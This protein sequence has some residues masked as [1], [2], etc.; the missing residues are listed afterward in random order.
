MWP[1]GP[2]RSAKLRPIKN[3][4]QAPLRTET[5]V[6]SHKMHL[7]SQDTFQGRDL[8][9]RVKQVSQQNTS[10]AWIEW[11]AQVQ[12]YVNTHAVPNEEYS[13]LLDR[14]KALL[15]KCG[16]ENCRVEQILQ[17][18]AT[19]RSKMDTLWQDNTK[20]RLENEKMKEIGEEANML[21][22]KICDVDRIL[23]EHARLNSEIKKLKAALAL[24]DN[25][26]VKRGDYDK[27][28]QENT[29]LIECLKSRDAI[30]KELQES[31]K[32]SRTQNQ[33]LI[34]MQESVLRS[35]FELRLQLDQGCDRFV[36]VSYKTGIERSLD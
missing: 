13:A 7:H 21:R 27:T 2:K 29:H 17:E 4:C 33:E 22:A 14:H 25:S 9:S 1:Q 19:F 10:D 6:S 31:L 32:T 35:N 24:P 3:D 26:F 23:V 16:E 30:I 5:P 18:S 12:V 20:L 8:I 15:A 34:T 36:D 11:V 28:K